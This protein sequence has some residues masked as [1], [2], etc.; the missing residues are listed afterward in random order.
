MR[1][2]ALVTGASRGIGRAV[3]AVLAREGWAVCVNYLE[4]RDAAESL[5]RE[6]R[7]QGRAAMAFQADIA[8]RE[9]ANACVR[10]ASEELGPVELLVNNAGISR[11]GLFQDLDDAAWDRLLAV[12]LTGPR[13]AVLAVLPHMLSEKRGCVVNISSMWGLRGASC[14]AAYAATK[15][16]V[17]GLT[18]SLALEL[19]PSG[20]RVNCVAPGCVETD[21]VRVLGEDTRRMLAE[22]TPLGRLGRPEDVAEA[23]AFLASEKAAFITGQVLAADGGFV[24]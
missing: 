22:E 6:L 14:E 5:V 17:I 23:V 13:N 15:A 12:N 11:Q 10:A 3:A 4:R 2:S 8:D 1:R 24:V 16:G 9:S 18:R 20:I 21:M 7:A 19:A